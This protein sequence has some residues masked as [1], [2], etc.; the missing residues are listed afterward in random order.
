MSEA[1]YIPLLNPNEPEALLA[2][3]HVAAGQQVAA[4]ELLCTLE[5]TKSTAELTAP[6]AGFVVGLQAA[7]GALV[8]AGD[9]LCYLAETPD[10]QLP[11]PVEPHRAEPGGD[12]PVPAGLRIT[13]PALELARQAGLDLNRLPLGPLVTEKSLQ[14]YLGESPAAGQGLADPPFDATAILIYGAGGHG[15]AC[16]DLVRAV[17][18][19]RVVG[20]VDDGRP[21][22]ELVMGV[23]VLGGGEVLSHWFEQ[24]VRL[25]VN[26]VG[27]IGNLAVRVQVFDQLGRAGYACPA[28]VHPSA[29]LEPSA[30]LAA[31]VQVF[32]QAYVGSEA[33][34]GFGAII[35]TGA[36]VSHDCQLGAYT[37]IS[38]GAILAGAV[39]IEERV[40]VG[41]GTT[42]NL[43][44]HI[45]RGARIGNGA[46]IKSDLPANG[47]VRAGMLW[48]GD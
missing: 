37:N 16:L 7:A 48:P 10:W 6:V 41:M 46:T 30:S 14:A 36:I 31:G 22:G 20:F 8:R 19:Y 27:G 5:T 32:P 3:L 38:P 12:Q 43:G 42:I 28:V 1:V 2:G 17:G 24:G 44:A 39:Q 26:A 23:P 15:K 33:Q 25:A 34:V 29:V 4:G 47:I 18:G 13:K 11:A 40:L 21:A 45:G 9:V 35:N